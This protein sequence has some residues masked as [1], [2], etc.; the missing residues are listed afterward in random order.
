MDLASYTSNIVVQYIQLQ[1]KY[2]YIPKVKVCFI[3]QT[4]TVHNITQRRN[5][6]IGSDKLRLKKEIK[7][8]EW[9]ISTAAANRDVHKAGCP[10]PK[11][12]IGRP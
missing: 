11:I 10:Q 2:F 8:T 6:R 9:I 1:Y 4:R 7:G 3:L 5:F 12:D